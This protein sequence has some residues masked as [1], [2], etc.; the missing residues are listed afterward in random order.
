MDFEFAANSEKTRQAR[1]HVFARLLKDDNLLLRQQP[2]AILAPVSYRS[3]CCRRQ[4]KRLLL[5]VPS[6]CFENFSLGLRSRFLRN[7]K[8]G[9]SVALAM[10]NQQCFSGLQAFFTA[11]TDPIWHPATQVATNMDFAQFFVKSLTYW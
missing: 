7:Q 8:S 9:A 5:K 6:I 3:S 2:E 11:E 10:E 4:R 1:C